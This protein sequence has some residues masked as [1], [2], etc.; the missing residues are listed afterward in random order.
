[1][2][3]YLIN[4]HANNTIAIAIPYISITVGKNGRLNNNT[5]EHKAVV[6]IAKPR[7]INICFLIIII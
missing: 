4:T 5:V 7:L 6:A 1:M 2:T 3:P